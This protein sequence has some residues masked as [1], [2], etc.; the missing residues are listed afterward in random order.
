MQPSNHQ[1]SFFVEVQQHDTFLHQMET[2]DQ[3]QPNKIQKEKNALFGQ[4]A[5]KR[6]YNNLCIRFGT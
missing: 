6:R 5:C 1:G 4:S 3:F 2:K